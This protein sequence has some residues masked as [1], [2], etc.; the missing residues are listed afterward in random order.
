MRSG[1]TDCCASPND[2]A[3]AKAGYGVNPSKNPAKTVNRTFMMFFHP[4]HRFMQI[5]LNCLLIPLGWIWYLE[6]SIGA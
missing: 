1:G 4:F 2:G 3:Y 5:N 6:I